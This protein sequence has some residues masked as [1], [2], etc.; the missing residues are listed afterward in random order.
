M[1]EK[2]LLSWPRVFCLWCKSLR[3]KERGV[4][5]SNQDAKG[6]RM[7]TP[8]GGLLGSQVEE[9]IHIGGFRRVEGD[10]PHGHMRRYQT[11]IRMRTG[12]K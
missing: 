12:S 9:D 6:D 3:R 8:R 4:L 7:V 11:L 10:F 1:R 5:V 2:S